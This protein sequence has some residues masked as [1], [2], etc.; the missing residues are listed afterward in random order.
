MLS[1]KLFFSAGKPGATTIG[2]EAAFSPEGG[3]SVAEA[4]C[5]MPR[6]EKMAALGS[7]PKLVPARE[8]EE[9]SVHIAQP[10]LL[11]CSMLVCC[12]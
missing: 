6:L 9:S 12:H 1:T 11:D 3:T 4:E 2:L 8:G 5:P 10:G 7:A